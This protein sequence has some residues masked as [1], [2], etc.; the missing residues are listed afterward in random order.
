MIVLAIAIAVTFVLVI[1]FLVAIVIG[2]HLA[3]RTD[4]AV[5]RHTRLDAMTRAV[6]GLH[7]HRGGSATKA[8]SAVRRE[9]VAR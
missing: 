1:G 6:L 7:V 8:A 9:R 3:H 4:L 5:Q 2:I